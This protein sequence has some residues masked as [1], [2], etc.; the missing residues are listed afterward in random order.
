MSELPEAA[1]LASLSTRAEVPVLDA[2]CAEEIDKA[3]SLLDGYGERA[4]AATMRGIGLL[5]RVRALELG[6]RGI[7]ECAT[8]EL[9]GLTHE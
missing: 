2:W 5:H 6:L 8:A 3:A 1:I 4:M 7:A 9:G